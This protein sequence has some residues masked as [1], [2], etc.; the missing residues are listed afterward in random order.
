MKELVCEGCGAVYT[1][2]GEQV[3]SIIQC[4]CQETKFKIKS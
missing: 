2:N 1:F 4:Y 3:P